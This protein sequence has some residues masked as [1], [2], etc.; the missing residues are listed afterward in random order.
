[1]KK[2]KWGNVL[3]LIIVAGCILAI[4]HDAYSV[5]FNLGGF[6]M[7]G[8]L[9]HILTWL[10]LDYICEDLEEQVMAL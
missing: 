5:A 2:I 9:T 10:V 6:T 4:L 8:L 7:F 3:K 1:M